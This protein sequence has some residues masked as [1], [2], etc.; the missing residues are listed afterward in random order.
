MRMPVVDLVAR[1]VIAR[2][3]ARR[4]SEQSRRVQ[5]LIDGRDGARRPT[6]IILFGKTPTNRQRYRPLKIRSAT[7]RHRVRCRHLA[8]GGR[9]ERHRAGQ[10]HRPAEVNGRGDVG[11]TLFRLVQSPLKSHPDEALIRYGRIGGLCC[12][13]LALEKRQLEAQNSWPRLSSS[14]LGRKVLLFLFTSGA[15]SRLC[16]RTE[17]ICIGCP[18]K[19]RLSN[20]DLSN[21][22]SNYLHHETAP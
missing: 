14:R 20:G 3:D 13:V 4:N 16:K 6:R 19:A 12:L 7:C 17:K 22:Q 18:S 11:V 5:P 21:A 15:R 8:A 10:R 1:A 9:G 2:C